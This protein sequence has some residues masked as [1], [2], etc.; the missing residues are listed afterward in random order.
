MRLK[1]LRRSICYPVAGAATHALFRTAA[2]IPEPVA[3]GL[4]RVFAT[5]FLALFG[6]DRKLMHTNLRIAYPDW[7]DARRRRVAR[8]SLAHAIHN[9]IDFAR[10]ARHPHLIAQVAHLDGDDA[11]P[12]RELGRNPEGGLMIIPHLGSW[13]M[14]SLAGPCVGIRGTAVASTFRNPHVDRLITNVRES[15]GVSIIPAHG[16]V[17]GMV[18][19]LR[20]GRLVGIL[21]DQNTR[22]SDGGTFVDFFGLPATVSRAPSR[23]ARKLDA[24]IIV[25]TFVRRAD[26]LYFLSTKLPRRAVDYE[27]E[28]ALTQALIDANEELIRQ[29]PE[30]YVWLYKR[31]RYIPTECDPDVAARFP[32]YARRL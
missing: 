31:W 28:Q 11:A 4:S 5:V 10:C 12:F 32:Y 9:M 17:K 29:Y 16:A 24:D 8:Q 3:A 15:T 6:G 25:A 13:E 14:L 7:D 2:A 30:Q 27:S 26:G 19:A 21:M 1:D 18:R 20:A 22:P 23:L